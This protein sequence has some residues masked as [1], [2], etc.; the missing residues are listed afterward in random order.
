MINYRQISD[1]LPYWNTF[2]L[3]HFIPSIYSSIFGLFWGRLLFPRSFLPCF[4]LV[5]DRLLFSVLLYICPRQHPRLPFTLRLDE[6]RTRLQKI[7]HLCHHIK[8][9]LA[10]LS[11]SLILSLNISLSHTLSPRLPPLLYPKCIESLLVWNL[12]FSIPLTIFISFSYLMNSNL[13][14]TF[15]WLLSLPLTD[16][17]G[18]KNRNQRTHHK[19]IRWF[20]NPVSTR[21]V[22]D[23]RCFFFLKKKEKEL[24]EFFRIIQKRNQRTW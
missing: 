19:P 23:S 3:F 15:P 18:T 22:D 14:L 2:F 1:L 20:Y 17:T 7:H 12:N 21:V 6:T 16:Y 10:L 9:L 11:L 8:F 13:S 24:V 5:F 4:R